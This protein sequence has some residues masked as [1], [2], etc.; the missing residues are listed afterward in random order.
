MET[1]IQTLEKILQEKLEQKLNAV[2]FHK[3]D[4]L[5]EEIKNLDRIIEIVKE[6]KTKEV[7]IRVTKTIEEIHTCPVTDEEHEEIVSGDIMLED[8]VYGCGEADNTVEEM[9]SEYTYERVSMMHP[10]RL[11]GK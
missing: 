10:G 3:V 1:K 6:E 9:N 5:E 7:K 11:E 4:A 8:I 2:G